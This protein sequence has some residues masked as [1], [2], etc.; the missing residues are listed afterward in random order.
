MTP[1]LL[2]PLMSLQ[3]NVSF[4]VTPFT[5]WNGFPLMKEWKFKLRCFC[6]TDDF[7]IEEITITFTPDSSINSTACFSFAPVDDQSI[8]SDE[9]FIFSPITAN[10]L[11]SFIDG[12][13]PTFDIT[14][15]DNDSKRDSLEEMT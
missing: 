13:S 10:S 8:E 14:I 11:D 3:L 6:F 9:L 2:L 4:A 12:P 5:A 1:A 7:V 15:F